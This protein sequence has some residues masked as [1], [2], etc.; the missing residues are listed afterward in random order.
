MRIESILQKLFSMRQ[1]HVKLGLER[2]EK[3]LD[4]IGNPHK[5]LKCFHIAGSNGKGS[6][7]SF[8]ASILKEYGY[9]V[10]LYTS[11]H[12]VKFNE[13]IRING[14][15]IDDDFIC[16]FYNSIENII[17]KEEPT[18]F[19]ITT[20]MA[21]KYFYD[22][23]VDYAVIETGLGGRLDATNVITPL[24][25]LITSIS[26]E[27]TNILGD[28][29]EKIAFEKAGIIKPGTIVISGYMPKEAENVIRSRAI[30][31][32]CE[33]YPF[34]N[35][36]VKEKDFVEVILKDKKYNLYKTPLKGYH[37]LLNCSLA[38]KT[39]DVVLKLDDYLKINSGINNVVINS[40]IQG[41]Y[42]IFSDKPRIIFD[43]AHNPEGIKIFLEEFVKE[44]YSYSKRELIFGA[45]KDKDIEG[46]LKLL[47]PFYDNIYV[48]A[49]DN[50]RAASIDEIKMIANKININ[51]VPMDKPEDYVKIFF[52]ED[53]DNCLVVLGSMY[54]LGKIKSKINKEKL[55]NEN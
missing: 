4:Y 33:Y 15:E 2:I 36:V 40:G 35:F 29:L 25:S 21:F 20:A 32:K 26:L 8:L 47:V 1:F 9:K 6:T 49:V 54:L 51:V 7:A 41:R 3:L 27:H 34:D 16:S 46:M 42:E 24:A 37:Q 38:V 11:P 18:F 10:G 14:K 31:L 52:N 44:Y 28:T 17:E 55:D 53:K 39:L 19:E 43:S 12:F 50:E 23:N 5:K 45:M 13:R 30:E 22:N 48:T